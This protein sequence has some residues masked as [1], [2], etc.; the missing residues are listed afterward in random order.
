MTL[1]KSNYIYDSLL[2]TLY[3]YHIVKHG[4][5]LCYTQRLSNTRNYYRAK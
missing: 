1:E 4:K 5:P 3:E 2:A